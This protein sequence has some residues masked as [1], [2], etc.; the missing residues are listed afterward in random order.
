M[1]CFNL[2]VICAMIKRAQQVSAAAIHIDLPPA[3][4]QTNYT[5]GAVALRSI[6]RYYGKDLKTEQEFEELCAAGKIKGSHP[7]DIAKA[8]RTL[9]LR[10]TVKERM[11]LKD[12]LKYI[13]DKTPVICAIQAWGSKEQY[14]KLSSG[15]YVV[16][17]GYDD[18]NIYFQDPSAKD[19]RPHIGRKEFMRRWIDREAYTP[20]DPIK[21]RLG[22]V[23]KGPEPKNK[24]VVT[25][26]KKLP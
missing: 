9:G 1:N 24:V 13:D 21:V 19:S 7:E 20:N 4:Q 18:D 5:C 16:A 17:V 11:S 14:K 25:N 15:H 22:I 10:A 3:R 12:L 8:A 6:A 2:G 23:I 26:T